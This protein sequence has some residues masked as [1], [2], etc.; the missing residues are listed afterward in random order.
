[1]NN[2]SS[3]M[4]VCLEGNDDDNSIAIIVEELKAI[5]KRVSFPV[6]NNE[7]KFYRSELLLLQ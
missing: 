7:I 4:T 3:K 1:M 6:K 2:V 5:L